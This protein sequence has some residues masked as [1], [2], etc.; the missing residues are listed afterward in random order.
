MFPVWLCPPPATAG[1][2]AAAGETVTAAAAE[3]GGTAA[4]RGG[5]TTRHAGEGHP[6]AAGEQLGLA[7]Q[8]CGAALCGAPHESL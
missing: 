7:G 5:A 1:P 6:A 8:P 4:A 3:A 2:A